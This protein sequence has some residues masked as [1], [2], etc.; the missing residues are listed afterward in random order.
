MKT[1]LLHFHTTQDTSSESVSNQ[2]EQ[3]APQ[4]VKFQRNTSDS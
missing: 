1:H 2:T 3:Y 4:K